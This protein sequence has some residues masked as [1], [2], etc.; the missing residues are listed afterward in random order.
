MKKNRF[1][2]TA[3]SLFVL[4]ACVDLPVEQTPQ[5][6]IT[7][8]T[9]I[10]LDPGYQTK[11]SLHFAVQTYTSSDGDTYSALSEDYYTLIMKTIGLYSF[12]P[13][14]PYQIIVLRSADE[15]Q[16][17]SGQPE[18]SAGVSVGNAILIY[19]SDY[20][21]QVLAHELTHLI[22][23]EYMK[24]ALP[25]E[26]W[27]NEGLAVYIENSINGASAR[28]DYFNFVHSKLQDKTFTFEEL[29]AAKLSEMEPEDISVWYMQ[30]ASM[31]DYLL[32][33]GSSLGF[34]SLLNGLKNGGTLDS[35]L[36]TAYPG[37]WR[38][39]DSLYKSWR[40]AGRLQ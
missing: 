38:D 15:Y 33:Q 40:S 14:E 16:Q 9:G 29:R 5:S 19:N 30:A 13:K 18:W 7:R 11:Y 3:L 10:E 2:I 22:F 39:A 31:V 20:S 8:I 21:R 12:V 32:N 24:T 6:A 23:F 4:T 28:N 35:A 37:K 27:I 17:K 34:S 36:K 1:I 26:L 25:G